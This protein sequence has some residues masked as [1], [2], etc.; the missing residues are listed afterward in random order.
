VAPT[1]AIS[2]AIAESEFHERVTGIA[3]QL[4]SEYRRAADDADGIT[5]DQVSGRES[6]VAKSSAARW[7]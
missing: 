7:G 5:H 6:A 1:P 4:L 3:E 2:G